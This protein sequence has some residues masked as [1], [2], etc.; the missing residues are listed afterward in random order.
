[1]SSQNWI[2]HVGMF[3]NFLA[4]IVILPSADFFSRTFQGRL[5]CFIHK[6]LV[7]KFSASSPPYAVEIPLNEISRFVYIGVASPLFVMI[8]RVFG[9]ASILTLIVGVSGLIL[10]PL[11]NTGGLS[12]AA[13]E[14][15]IWFSD[16]LTEIALTAVALL[17]VVYL[18][19]Y[20]SRKTLF[21]DV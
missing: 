15:L 19:L 16:I 20:A 7:D 2:A 6:M 14:L 17:L 11:G 4:V 21:K 18:A 1:M 9:P 12:E 13:Q 5:H 10:K 3:I 8:A